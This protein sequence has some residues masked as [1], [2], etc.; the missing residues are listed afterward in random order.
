[1]KVAL[2]L[3]GMPR[4]WDRIDLDDY[5]NVD[6][7]IH[8]WSTSSNFY[9]CLDKLYPKS[10]ATKY[11]ADIK[12]IQH[13]KPMNWKFES[14]NHKSYYFSSLYEKFRNCEGESRQSVIPMYYGVK[15]SIEMALDSGTKFDIIIRSRF[16]IKLLQQIRYKI[17]NSINIPDQFHHMGL[18]DQFAYGEPELMREY[19]KVY[20]Y[21]EDTPDIQLNPEI[22][23]KDFLHQKNININLTSDEFIILR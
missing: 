13:F 3:S 6:I 11:L 7:F 17:N 18:C 1:M 21:L 14:F 16:D 8:S 4:F 22:I 20:D 15:K 9:N 23:L 2:C 5:G 19:S 10:V 12:L